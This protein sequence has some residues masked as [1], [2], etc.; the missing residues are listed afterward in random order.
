M[1]SACFIAMPGPAL[2]Q[3]V[4]DNVITNANDAFGQSVGNERVGLY[5]NEDVRGFSPVDAGNARI[6]GLYFAPVDR[7]PNRL[8]RGSRVRVGIAAQGYP[9]P[10]PTGI[11]DFDLSA[12][13][14]ADQF[15]IGLER[16]QFGSV[17]GSLDS[18][19]ALGSG[20]RAYLGGTVRR[21]NRHEG[22]NFKSWI[23]SGG[24]AWRPYQGASVIAFWGKTRTYDDEAAPALF[25]GGDALP[26]QIPRRRMIG[27]SWSDRDN[28]QEVFGALAKLPLGDWRIE[29]GLFRAVRR[30]DANF[31]DIF[32]NL[33]A[34]GTVANRV[35][36]VD[37][38]NRDRTLSGEARVV[39]S[40]ADGPL[41]HRVTLS[42]RGRT[43]DRRF[44]GVQRISLGPSSILFAD[45]RRRPVITLGVDDTD[46]SAQATL[47]V[48]YT[49]TRPGRFLVDAAVAASRYSKTIRF[50]SAG[51][52]TS[53]RDRPVTGSITGNYSL[54][55]RLTFYGGY[56]RG[57]EE[58]AVAPQNATN[59]GAVPPAI[60]TSQTDLGFRYGLNKGLS[61][62]AGV[63]Q[64]SKP[65]YNLDDQLLY[66]DLGSSSNRGIEVSLTG[67]LRS[68]LTVV[69]GNVLI[70]SRITGLLVD[71]GR[72]GARPVGTIR[73]RSIANIDWRLDGGA[74]PLSLDAAFESLSARVGNPS[75]SLYAPP[76]ETLDL[77]MRYRFPLGKTR[78]L[79]RLQ[80]ANVFDGYGWQVSSN[81]AFLYSAGRRLLAELRFDL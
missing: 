35:M 19:F 75:N 49:L 25:P 41:A 39:R 22:G 18:N 37:G 76:R 44:G 65:Y 59:R 29:A 24:V 38:N 21:Q 66:R 5:S 14:D 4:D 50:V 3:R 72:I 15:T 40:F 70:D 33:R 61:L 47:G 11:V 79:L 43:G 34:D 68:G 20:L 17:L 13:S 62:V 51:L 8:A 54:T 1:A 69:L 71:E 32:A 60:R 80:M 55:P 27:Q 46:D 74:S 67:A 64:I 63:F 48:A 30:V 26:P 57:F 42:F 16:A 6:E 2:A 9:F 81:G 52:V 36:V 7:L 77:G 31:T 12:A 53:N 78:A 28:T 73:R 10:A 58:V 56:M 45:E 23:A